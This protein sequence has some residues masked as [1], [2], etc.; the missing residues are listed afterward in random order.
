MSLSTSRV[1]GLYVCISPLTG[2][3]GHNYYP[4]EISQKTSKL[5]LFCIYKVDMIS[6]IHNIYSTFTQF[7]AKNLV[8]FVLTGKWTS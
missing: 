4:L 5:I 6:C 8:I 1:R 2:D 3:S 7:N